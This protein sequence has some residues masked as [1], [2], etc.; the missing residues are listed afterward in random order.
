MIIKGQSRGRSAQL[1][2]HLLRTDQ[3][4]R[5]RSIQP[6]HLVGQ[7]NSGFTDPIHMTAISLNNATTALLTIRPTVDNI[8]FLQIISELS[9]DIG[10][11]A[12]AVEKAS[13]AKARAK[14]K[15]TKVAESRAKKKS[16]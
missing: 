2:V 6:V 9:N 15:P 4:E 11:V 1:A 12:L 16:P 7:S 8:I 10:D 5:V 13:L 14:P 3:N